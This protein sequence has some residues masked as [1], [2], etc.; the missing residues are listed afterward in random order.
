[1][2]GVEVGAVAG[3]SIMK[4]LSVI[5]CNQKVYVLSVACLFVIF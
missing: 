2:G 4:I 1:M 5:L 3:S